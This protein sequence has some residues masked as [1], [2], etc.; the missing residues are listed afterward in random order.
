[1]VAMGRHARRPLAV[2]G[3]GFDDV[4]LDLRSE[5]EWKRGQLLRLGRRARAPLLTSCEFLFGEDT[6]H[7]IMSIRTT[8]ESARDRIPTTTL[9]LEAFSEEHLQQRLIRD[10]ALVGQKLELLQHEIRQA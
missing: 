4:A 7:S 9:R 2:R 1:M 6:Y 3:H 5:A 10:I 8:G